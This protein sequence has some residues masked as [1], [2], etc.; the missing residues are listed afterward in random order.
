MSVSFPAQLF[1]SLLPRELVPAQGEPA[2]GGC[3]SLH[4]LRAHWKIRT[5]ILMI[6][7]S[8]GQGSLEAS[9]TKSA[10]KHLAS[11]SGSLR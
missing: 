10:I 8:T 1:M 2:V 11:G 5:F 7:E 9:R 6:Q 3:P 4:L